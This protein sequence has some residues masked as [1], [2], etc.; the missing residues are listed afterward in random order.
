MIEIPD[1]PAWVQ[2]IAAGG[3]IGAA[4][5]AASALAG[6]LLGNKGAAEANESREQMSQEQMK[7]QERMSNTQYQRGMADMRKAGLNPILAYQQGG[8]SSPVGAMPAVENELSGAASSAMAAA[9]LGAD[10]DNI[11]ADTKK[12]EE[13]AKLNRAL[14]GKAH[15]DTATSSAAAEKIRSEVTIRHLDAEKKGNYGDSFT[16]DQLNSIERMFKRLFHGSS[17]Y[18]DRQKNSEWYRSLTKP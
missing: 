16:G 9:Q 12:K 10:L 5:G 7:F 13:E 1:F 8:A 14:V 15:Q 2:V 6:S 4:I 3:W 17:A 18:V 11:K